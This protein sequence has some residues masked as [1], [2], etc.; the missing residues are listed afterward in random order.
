MKFKFKNIYITRIK[1]KGSEEETHSVQA[2]EAKRKDLL[3]LK[4]VIDHNKEIFQSK[5]NR[6]KFNQIKNKQLLEQEKKEI[7]DRG[8]NPNFYMP[9]KIKLDEFEEQRQRFEEEQELN[10]QQIVKK[11]LTEN[12]NLEKKKVLYP[13]LFNINLKPL[14][15]AAEKDKGDVQLL[16]KLATSMGIADENVIYF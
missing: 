1:D 15:Q 11:I 7:K 12:Q 4:N 13:N 3:A 6:N 14:K 2:N 8:E 9:R 10:K 5:V 16:A